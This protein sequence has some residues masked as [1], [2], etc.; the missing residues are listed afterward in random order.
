MSAFHKTAVLIDGLN[1]HYTAKALC[2]DI[3]FKRLQA[4][5]SE[6]TITRSSRMLGIARSDPYRLAELQRLHGLHRRSRLNEISGSTLVSIRSR[7][8]KPIDQ[9][10][11]I[12]GDEGLPGLSKQFRAEVGGHGRSNLRTSVPMIS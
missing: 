4:E 2:F 5:W 12:S 10:V 6:M 3:D 9:I 8:A 1:L 11:R 7:I